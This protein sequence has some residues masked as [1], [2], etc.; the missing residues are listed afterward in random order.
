MGRIEVR[1]FENGKPIQSAVAAMWT[2]FLNGR[3]TRDRPTKPGKYVIANRNGRVAGEV[4][5]FY[6]SEIG[7]LTVRV[8]DSALCS[9]KELDEPGIWWWSKPMPQLMPLAAPKEV[10]VR[11]HSRP[12]AKLKHVTCET[13][14]VRERARRYEDERRRT[15]MKQVGLHPMPD[16]EKVS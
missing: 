6:D 3:W 10:G 15:P 8:R 4:F 1:A 16:W 2:A 13:T 14:E 12:A 11:P 5:V 7:D 9:I